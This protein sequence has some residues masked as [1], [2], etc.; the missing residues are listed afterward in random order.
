MPKDDWAKNGKNWKYYN[1]TARRN[2]IL[3]KKKTR[4]RKQ[5]KKKSVLRMRFGQYEGR[6]FD[7]IPKSDLL[8]ILND[9]QI[10]EQERIRINEILKHWDKQKNKLQ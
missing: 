4:H 6:C 5:N 8:L 3:N 7:Q 10:T 1:P 2:T 9:S